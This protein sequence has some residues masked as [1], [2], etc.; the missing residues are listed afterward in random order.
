MIWDE[1]SAELHGVEPG[2]LQ[3][4]YDDWAHRVH[5]DDLE[6]TQAAFRKAL[7]GEKA[8]DVEY[9]V[10]SSDGSER[11]IKGDAVVV[12][13]K[14]GDAARVVG[15]NIDLT[16][17][18][19][20]EAGLQEARSIAV[21]AQKFD[22]IGQ[23]T[24]GVAHDFN[25]LLA[26]IMGNQE[27][28]K[29]ELLRDHLDIEDMTALIDASIDAT[30]RG[31]EL[32]RNMLAYARRARLEPEVTDLNQVVRETETWLRRTIE[33]SI[34][35]ETVLQAG[36]WPTKVDRVS[37]QSA[38][39]NL[40]VNARDAFTGPGKVTIETA[41][42]KMDAEYVVE[43][44]E[45]VSLG[46][47]VM[48]AISDNAGGIAPDILEKIFDP[49]FTTKPVGKGSGL[50]LSMVQGFVKQSGGVVRVYSEVGVGTSFKLYFP[51]AEIESSG[52]REPGSSK[53]SA[54]SLDGGGLR[55]L[56]V[57]DQVKLL[58]LLER[59]LRGAGY[60]V[61]T[62]KSGVEAYRL[63]TKEPKFDLVLTD[64]VMPG[65]LQG[66]GLAKRIRSDGFNPRFIFMSGYASEAVVHGNGLRSDDIRLMKPVTRIDLLRAVETALADDDTSRVQGLR[67]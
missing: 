63:F 40:L 54:E 37:L 8:F 14:G 56:L 35:I 41:N 45:D 23:L 4:T 58:T 3:G 24:G 10:R 62:A 60:D 29:D 17:L 21:Q 53:E 47:Y 1:R 19:A 31:A 36:L 25:N 6:A 34:E 13:D 64:I 65:E 15:S 38:V 57:E 30:R 48:L 33:S 50:G 61:R 55:L 26:I 67:L 7:A 2:K 42:T 22:T 28:L 49:F 59:M 66:P 11:A 39:V 20:A 43:R 44:Y 18:R 27:L 16:E 9:R 32:T 46:R 51:A 52:E 5:P 12:R